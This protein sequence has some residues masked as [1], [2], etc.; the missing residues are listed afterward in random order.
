MTEEG[1]LC[2]VALSVNEFCE[3]SGKFGPVERVRVTEQQFSWSLSLNC[4]FVMVAVAYT[5]YLNFAGK[6]C[7]GD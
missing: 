1:P 7:H 5:R 2:R 3:V 6:S 4:P